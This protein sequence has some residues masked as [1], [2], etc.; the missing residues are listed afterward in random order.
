MQEWWTTRPTDRDVIRLSKPLANG[1]KDQL[2]C[3]SDSEPL[4]HL[5]GTTRMQI[6]TVKGC[7]EFIEKHPNNEY[8]DVKPVKKTKARK[9]IKNKD[10]VWDNYNRSDRGR[11]PC[12]ASLIWKV[13][14][15]KSH[16]IAHAEG[17]NED[18]ENLIPLCQKC[19]SS[20]GTMSVFEFMI[21]ILRGMRRC[22]L[23]MARFRGIK[24][25]DTDF[26]IESLITTLETLHQH[27]SL[28]YI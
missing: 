16:I 24:L 27:A 10:D 18:I 6:I 21:Q 3:Y 13:H 26:P 28:Q 15:H 23:I 14:H 5:Q 7:E 8:L 1:H 25:N 20:M 22:V 2:S 11:C 17:G 4:N 12:C 19:N 9:H